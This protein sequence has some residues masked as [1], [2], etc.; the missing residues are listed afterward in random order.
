[1]ENIKLNFVHVCE[2]AFLSNDGKLNIIGIFNKI[3]T[4]E[5]PFV[6]PKFFIVTS[7]SGAPAK[8]MENIEIISNDNDKILNI[9]KE[10]SINKEG[11]SANFIAQFIGVP[12]AEE[13]TYEIKVSIN[14]DVVK[15]GDFIILR[16]KE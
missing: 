14:G 9:Q 12:F 6:H 1:M 13:G 4:P 3:I 10:I 5:F 2:N 11:E 8:Y 7:I 15:K 16:K